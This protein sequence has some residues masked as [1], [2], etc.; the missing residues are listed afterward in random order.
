[1]SSSQPISVIIPY[2]PTHTPKEMLEE[3]KESVKRQ[4]VRTNIII[5]TDTEQY[6]PAWARNKG[7]ERT[8][9]K[10]AAFLDADD[11]WCDNK[12]ERQ[13]ELMQESGSA[14]CVEGPHMSTNEFIRS[15]LGGDLSSLTSSILLN[16]EQVDIRFEESLK[17]R[18]DHLFVVEAASKGGVCL[19]PNLVK[20]R[21]HPDGLSNRDTAAFEEKNA[22]IFE[23]LLKE[24]VEDAEQYIDVYQAERYHQQGRRKYFQHDYEEATTLFINSLQQKVRIKT[25]GALVLNILQW[26]FQLIRN[27][28]HLLDRRI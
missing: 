24:R 13:L 16:T 8:N 22:E 28:K 12:L 20:I 15:I 27:R 10:Y 25:L 14:I 21:K 6:G 11:L 9:T 4:S 7:L 2:S 23:R 18:E 3:A 17:R 5:V 19:C 1:M 26:S